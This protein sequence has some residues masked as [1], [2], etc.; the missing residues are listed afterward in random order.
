LI[1]PDNGRIDTCYISAHWEDRV[2]PSDEK[3]V[4]TLP[5]YGSDMTTEEIK[6]SV[7][8]RR[9]KRFIYS[10]AWPTPGRSYYPDAPFHSVVDNGWVDFVAKV[11]KYKKALMENQIFIKYHIEIPEYYWEQKYGEQ[12]GKMNTDEKLQAK[13]ETTEQLVEILA[14]GENAGK[15]LSTSFRI[16][17]AGKALPGVK[18]TPIDDKIKDGMYIPDAKAGNDEILFAL[19][20]HPTLKGNASP[21]SK[22]GAGSGS[23]SD[24]REAWNL[25]TGIKSGHREASL[26][27]LDFIHEY[28]GWSP[29]LSYG[30]KDMS[31]TTLDKNPTGTQT[32]NQ[33]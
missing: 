30:Y 4:I 27:V 10:V 23:G 16:D 1:K 6:E 24:I 17:E 3:R 12:W 7:I 8:K 26:E 29:E 20:I 25:H 22:S 19:G 5:H 13:I 14:G 31:M 15:A 28:N 11:P 21:G 32:V 2:L 9:E 33:G 18:I